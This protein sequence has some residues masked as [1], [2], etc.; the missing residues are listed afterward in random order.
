MTDATEANEE[1]ANLAKEDIEP[2]APRTTEA[3][4]A[5]DVRSLE[6]QGERNLYL[7]LKKKDGSWSFPQGSVEKGEFLHQV[8]CQIHPALCTYSQA[9]I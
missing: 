5:K 4:H 3:D 8:T 9:D 7:L 2:S 1:A 6:R